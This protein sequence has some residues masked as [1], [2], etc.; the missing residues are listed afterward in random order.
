MN[1]LGTAL[2]DAIA[3]SFLQEAALFM[4][5]NIPGFPPIIQTVHILGIAVVMGSAVLLNLRMLGLVVP[6]H[7]ISEMTSRVMPWFWWALASNAFS[8]SFFVFGRPNRYFSNPVFTWKMSF[9]L[10]AVQWEHRRTEQS[11]DGFF[12]QS[13]VLVFRQP[14]STGFKPTSRST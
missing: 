7:S 2:A 3:G 6:S 9:L 13:T 14:F 4:L 1:G 10:A 12:A 8:G 11:K 5:Q